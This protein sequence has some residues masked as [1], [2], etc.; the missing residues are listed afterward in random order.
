MNCFFFFAFAILTGSIVPVNCHAGIPTGFFVFAFLTF[1]QPFGVNNYDPTEK[2]RPIFV[3][4][5]LLFGV[6]VS[7]GL[8]FNE[9]ILKPRL[10][11][12]M[13]QG[14]VILWIG[15][16]LLSLSTVLFIVYNFP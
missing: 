16:N 7:L 5:M 2:L 10:N 6:I 14:G 12:P 1:F 8:A 4:A 11:L 9:F 15:W 3:V 13:T